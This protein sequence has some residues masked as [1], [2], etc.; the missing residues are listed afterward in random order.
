MLDKVTDRDERVWY[1]QA[2]IQHGWS[3]A[4]LAHQIESGLYRR[5]GKPSRLRLRLPPPRSDLAQE[6]TKDPYNFDFLM[7]G[8]AA[9]ERD[10]NLSGGQ[11]EGKN[12]DM[13]YTNALATQQPLDT[14]ANVVNPANGAHVPAFAVTSLLE[15][16]ES[17]YDRLDGEGTW[18][19]R[20]YRTLLAHY[21]KFL[22][23]A[24]ASVLEVGCGAGELLA[25]LP[26]R[27]I[28]GVDLSGRQIDRARQ[29]LP[30]GV[31][32]KQA[33]ELLDVNRTF[34]FVILSDTANF[35][36]DLQIC[37]QRLHAV[38][39]PKTRLILN[40]HSNLWRPFLAIAKLLR[41]QAKHPA[42]NWLTLQDVRNFLLLGDWEFI[43]AE[44]RILM[45]V[46]LFGLDAL[47]NRFV[48]PILPFLC[49]SVFV[50]ARPKPFES[51][52]DYT[53]TVVVPARNEAGNIRAAV[54]RLPALGSG[55]ELIF[56]EG[57][58]H[59]DTWEEIQRVIRDNRSIPIRAMRQTGKGKGNAV[60]EAF[61]VATG[62]ILMIL[63]ADLTMPPEELP[64]YYE[65]LRT[66]KAEFANGVRLVYP[67]DEE[68]MRF[69]NLCAN[70]LFSVM[71]SW[72]LGQPIKDTLCGTKALLKSD[73][74]RIAANRSYFGGLDPFGDF[75][76]LF[77]AGRL[78][79]K[80][81]D[82]PVR[83][84]EREYGSTNI[85]R[86]RHGV[87]LA[88]MVDLAARRLKFI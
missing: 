50:I 3:R 5:Q 69:F 13:E 85:Q 49:L 88:R 71:F 1:A 36:A 57:H 4:V 30:H 41:L 15:K 79:L 35:A 48:A 22:I 40:F 53:V 39:H 24:D 16:T 9:R 77:G 75:D 26:N 51:A 80:M 42:L 87:L 17:F 6:V 10:W 84:R 20:R 81:L 59:D 61:E 11:I 8:E 7:L 18:A 28:A 43:R 38:A 55:T 44:P 21:Y 63:D 37:F 12:H 54:A 65:A 68:A 14:S 23:P 46:P 70:K 33:A 47:L 27:D 74:L 62:E 86:W 64:K 78:H 56:V 19:G 66:G 45:P 31:F 83:Y 58:S 25:L 2:A 82:I 76:L 34:D 73:Y 29:R 72:L 52:G 60:R 32:V 67:M